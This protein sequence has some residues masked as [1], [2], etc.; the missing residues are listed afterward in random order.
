MVVSPCV[1]QSKRPADLAEHPS[2]ESYGIRTPAGMADSF[3]SM[4]TRLLFVSLCPGCP[5]GLR[6]LDFLA[7][8]GLGLPPPS[9]DGGL[10]ELEESLNNRAILRSRS[11]I[12]AL[13]LRRTSTMIFGSL[14][15]MA[16]AS[17]LVMKEPVKNSDHPV[18]GMLKTLHD[19]ARLRF[20]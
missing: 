18:N 17:S 3:S 13:K 14:R 1:E 7:G 9:E 10:E 20:S 15:A 6:F 5:P 19:C 2:G 12:R 8:R 16:M 4:G 11:T